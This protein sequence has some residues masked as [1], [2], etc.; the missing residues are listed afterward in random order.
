MTARQ[1]A[2]I[3]EQ[4]RE[5]VELDVPWAALRP[6]LDWLVDELTADEADLPTA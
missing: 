5:L 1:A 3:L 2:N 6:I 4:V